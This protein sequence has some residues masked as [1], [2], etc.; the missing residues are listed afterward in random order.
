MERFLGGTSA[1]G[2][3]GWEPKQSCH[4]IL[5]LDTVPGI[6]CFGLFFGYSCLY[7]LPQFL[8]QPIPFCGLFSF[9]IL[10]F[11]PPRNFFHFHKAGG[12]IA[13]ASES[14]SR[15]RFAGKGLPKKSLAPASIASGRC[16]SGNRPDMSIMGVSL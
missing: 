13:R 16:S 2:W 4:F 9:F 1:A 10:H 8:P 12:L 14:F 7:A 15:S 6:P 3:Q 5:G 11:H